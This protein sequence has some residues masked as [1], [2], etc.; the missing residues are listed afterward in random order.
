MRHRLGTSAVLALCLEELAFKYPATKFVSIVSTECIP[1]YPDQNLPTVLVYHRTQCVRT[2]AGLAAL[3]D[4]GRPRRVR[5]QNMRLDP[6]ARYA[7]LQVLKDC[8]CAGVA[9]ALNAVGP[10]CAAPQD[11]EQAAAAQHAPDD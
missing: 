1:S 6:A 8:R 9:A 5:P 3:V 4:C 10:V 7:W 2:L 11:Q